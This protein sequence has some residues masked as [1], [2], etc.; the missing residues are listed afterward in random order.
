MTAYDLKNLLAAR[1]YKDVFVPECK[2]GPTI[3]GSHLRLDA[4][5][6]NRSWSR[7][8][9]FGY[10]IKVSRSDFLRD[11]KYL[12]Y[13]DM[14][15]VLYL[16][17]PPGILD[18]SE[19]PKDVGWLVSTK[20]G[21]KLLTKKKAVHRDIDDPIDLYRYILMARVK[22]SQNTYLESE[23]SVEYWER[24]L[25]NKEYRRD[26]GSRVSQALRQTIKDEIEAVRERQDKLEERL[27]TYAELEQI[28]DDLNIDRN[29]VTR[30]MT[31]D[32]KRKLQEIGQ[33]FPE[34]LSI[35]LDWTRRTALDLIKYID[36]MK[37]ELLAGGDHGKG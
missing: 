32:V 21:T 16:V 1:H 17:T 3:Y 33:D 15:H 14:C 6:M 9:T 2:N 10:E 19:I 13:R 37:T 27:K 23:E 29:R 36:H 28:L 8:C 31:W 22:V 11:E 5:A 24:W 34:H 30:F 12:F 7:F 25:K 26:L 20:N 35:Q 4:W 18:K